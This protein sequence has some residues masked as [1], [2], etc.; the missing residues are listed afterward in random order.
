MKDLAAKPASTLTTGPNVGCYWTLTFRQD[1]QTYTSNCA[2]NRC[3]FDKHTLSATN[4]SG[5]HPRLAA[6]TRP[7]NLCPLQ[8]LTLP[9]SPKWE[10]TFT[11]RLTLCVKN[12]SRKQ[13]LQCHSVLTG[14]LGK[15]EILWF[16]WTLQQ[17]GCWAELLTH[18]SAFQQTQSWRPTVKDS[19]VPTA[20]K[21]GGGRGLTYKQFAMVNTERNNRSTPSKTPE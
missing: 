19:H 12:H 2:F 1:R 11:Q 16:S 9:E 13:V 10:A 15:E 4:C 21:R 14:E 6:P 8:S 20:Q 17:G 3:P 5:R 7:C 18:V